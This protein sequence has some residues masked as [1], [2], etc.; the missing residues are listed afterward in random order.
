VRRSLV[1]LAMAG[2]EEAFATLARASGDRLLAVAYRILRDVG[3]A[4]DAVQQTL[5]TA[6]R[7]LPSL[8]DP[9]RFEAWLHRLLV[10]ACYAEGR[11]AKRSIGYVRVLP[12]DLAGG[13]DEYAAV[14]QRDELDRV[15]PRLPP[16]Q[17]VVIVFHYYLGLSHQE[18]ADHL[19][20]PL[21][22][23]KSRLHT[24]TNALR[25]A[26]EADERPTASSGR[27]A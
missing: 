3:L 1:D 8:R 26:L 14:A 18:I 2:N 20:I 19:E 7:Q 22:T 13:S 24:A 4:E 27:L 17:R 9:D 23:V 21:G 25:A 12:I 15:F 16:E 5:V 6:W 10:H 11:R